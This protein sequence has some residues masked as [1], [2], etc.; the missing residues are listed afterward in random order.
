MKLK[1]VRTALFVTLLAL[2]M[3]AIISQVNAQ[4][5]RDYY[6]EGHDAYYALLGEAYRAGQTFTASTTYTITHVKA[7]LY[8]NTGDADV[9]VGLMNTEDGLPAGGIL[10]EDYIA[11]ALI[12]DVP[13]WYQF[14][15][16]Y[17]VTE[18]VQYAIVFKLD[19]GIGKECRIRYDGTDPTYDGGT[20]VEVGFDDWYIDGTKDFM[21]EV[22]GTELPPP[23]MP[24]SFFQL[25]PFLGIAAALM[26][27]TI[28][29]AVSKQAGGTKSESFD[30]IIIPLFAFLTVGI[31]TL[32][33]IILE[34]ML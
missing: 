9:Y 12:A 7:I 30:V 32:A 27:I 33:I 11:G 14:D 26:F 22:W 24:Y 19:G 13:T 23:K 6:N 2:T 5:L 3:L 20:F 21:F 1:N 34:G 16:T 31:V 25:L 4:T 28:F 8:L 18:G 15:F 29:L 17:T 10:A